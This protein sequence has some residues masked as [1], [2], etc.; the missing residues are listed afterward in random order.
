MAVI[1]IENIKHFNKLLTQFESR[2]TARNSH[3]LFKTLQ[4]NYNREHCFSH[5]RKK[6]IMAVIQIENIKHFIKLLTQ[7]ASPDKV[8][9]YCEK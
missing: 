1:Q 8:A 3:V 6:S 9:R 5:A 7:F 4:I 2:H